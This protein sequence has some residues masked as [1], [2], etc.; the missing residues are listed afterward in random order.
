MK[1]YKRNC[2][3]AVQRKTYNNPNDINGYQNYAEKFGYWKFFVSDF[4][5]KVEQFG[6]DLIEYANIILVNYCCFANWDFILVTNPYYYMEEHLDIKNFGGK[7]YANEISLIR[8]RGYNTF[9]VG[10]ASW[11][12]IPCP[13]RDEGSYYAFAGYKV[14]K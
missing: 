7:A 14:S 13:G 10:P 6:Q 11:S 3:K 1:I 9:L 2:N 5:N 12:L 4:S 8:K